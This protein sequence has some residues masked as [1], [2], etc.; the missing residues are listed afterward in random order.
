M[1]E[2]RWILDAERSSLRFGFT[3]ARREPVRG[4]FDTWS[5]TLT[6]DP[7]ALGEAKVEVRV[8]AESVETGDL[9]TNEVLRGRLML[10]VAS[11]RVFGFSGRQAVLAHGARWRLLGDLTIKD[12][13]V[14]LLVDVGWGGV[15]PE[16]T[17]N[18]ARASCTARCSFDPARFGVGPAIGEATGPAMV[19]VEI[20]AE[21][22]CETRE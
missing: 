10:D 5:A 12:S 15:V 22:V 2:R 17:Q 1:K 16:G 21:F 6:M 18:S 7:D 11:H 9:R 14:P 13:T 20:T 8:A 19:E 4:S 3:G